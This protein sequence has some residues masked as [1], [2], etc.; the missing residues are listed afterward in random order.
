MKR[1]SFLT[2]LGLA[3]AVAAMPEVVEAAEPVFEAKEVS[4]GY[5]ITPYNLDDPLPDLYGNF[6]AMVRMSNEID[7]RLKAAGKIV[8]R[9]SGPDYSGPGTLD[10]L[11]LNWDDDDD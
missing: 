5:K 2:M 6:S 8:P 4:I 1:R 10:D 9:Y 11:I 3:P 7:A